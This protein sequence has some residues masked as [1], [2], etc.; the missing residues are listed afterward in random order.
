MR[1]RT[2]IKRYR[3]NL[4]GY[5]QYDD[6]IGLACC[7]EQYDLVYVFKVQDDLAHAVKENGRVVTFHKT[8]ITKEGFIR[9]SY[10]H[11]KTCRLG[12]SSSKSY[13][14]Q[15]YYE[16]HKNDCHKCQMYKFKKTVKRFRDRQQNGTHSNK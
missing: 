5:W 6:T 15:G 7:V 11:H 14:K 3:V 2:R 4:Y 9:P 13:K 10:Q 12:E 1:Y 16:R 8:H